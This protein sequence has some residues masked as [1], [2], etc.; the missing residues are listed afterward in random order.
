MPAFYIVL[1]QKIAGTDFAIDNHAL[2]KHIHQLD[3]LA[4][5]AGV[6]TLMSFFSISPEEAADLLESPGAAEPIVQIPEEKWFEAEEGLK[7]IESLLRSLR[8]SSSAE[9]LALA[10]ELG[11]F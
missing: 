3:A 6:K 8:D 9:N 4:N 5:E 2:S 10:A 1:Q 11:D 7:T